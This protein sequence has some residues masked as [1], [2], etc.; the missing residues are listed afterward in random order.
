MRI[1][2]EGNI[3]SGK[4]VQIKKFGGILEPIDDWPLDLFYSDP[5]RWSLVL[6]ISILKGFHSIEKG[7]NERSPDSSLEIFWNLLEH[8]PD[9]DIA[10]RFVHD[11]L[12]WKPDAIVYIRT[13]PE[14][15]FKRL[16]TRGQTGD[17]KITLKYLQ[18]IHE[19]YEKYIRTKSNVL[20]VDGLETPLR[21]YEKINSYIHSNDMLD[22]SRRT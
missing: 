1:S 11:K 17:S 6:Q 13:P 21:I 18:D 10:Y 9:E 14:V 8:T 20:V 2:F 3:A 16:Q 4:S 22:L 12:G 19:R 5:N 15:C 7:I